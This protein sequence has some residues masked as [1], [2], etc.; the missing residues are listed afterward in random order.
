MT[1]RWSAEDAALCERKM[2][3]FAGPDLQ[4][5]KEGGIVGTDG[6]PLILFG[7]GRAGRGNADFV[8]D[9]ENVSAEGEA[10]ALRCFLFMR[11][12]RNALSGIPGASGDRVNAVSLEK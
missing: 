10:P 8:I 4:T 9:G 1:G 3:V 2:N 5:G 6:G 11:M 12:K 7:G